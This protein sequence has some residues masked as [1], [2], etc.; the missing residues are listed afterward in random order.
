MH[1]HGSVGSLRLAGLVR[2]ATVDPRRNG[3]FS[4]VRNAHCLAQAVGTDGLM[5]GFVCSAACIVKSETSPAVV[6]YSH[7]ARHNPQRRNQLC[8]QSYTLS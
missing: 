3:K 1:A 5:Q 2:G 8:S 6:T 4:R 7:T